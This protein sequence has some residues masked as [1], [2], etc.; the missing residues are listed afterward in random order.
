M[1][2]EGLKYTLRN[3]KILLG[4]SIGISNEQI[5]EF[6]KVK[7]KKGILLVVKSKD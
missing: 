1:T 7:V 5:S 3:K 6:A 2:L 4:E